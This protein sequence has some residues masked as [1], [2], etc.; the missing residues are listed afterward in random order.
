MHQT[1]FE[2][3]F[4]AWDLG[5]NLY[6]Q[7]TQKWNF[8]YYSLCTKPVWPLFI[9]WNTKGVFRQNETLSHH[10]SSLPLGLYNECE[11]GLR[12]TIF[13]PHIKTGFRAKWGWEDNRSKNFC[14]TIITLNHDCLFKFW[15]FN[16][17]VYT[18]YCW[19]CIH[20][21]HIMI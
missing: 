15:Y 19:L 2:Y 7:L 3:Q 17:G 18:V 16:L 9:L 11:Y 5:T 4:Y 13:V 6:G 8:C 10:S 1:Y 21:L 14:R 20:Y 12:L